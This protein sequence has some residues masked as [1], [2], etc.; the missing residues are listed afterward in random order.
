M[1]A[2]TTPTFSPR[3]AIATARFTVTELLPTP[4]LPDAT[5]IDAGQRAGLGERDLVRRGVGAADGLAQGLALRVVHHVEA[6]P[7]HAGHAGHPGDRLGD[8]GGDR[9]AHRAARHGE[10]DGDVDPAL[11]VA[12]DVLDHAE[13]GERAVD[14]R[15]LDG[16]QRGHEVVDGG[17]LVHGGVLTGGVWL[18]RPLYGGRRARLPEGRA[19]GRPYPVRYDRAGRSLTTVRDDRSSR[20]SQFLRAHAHVT[21]LL[22]AEL[23]AAHGLSLAEYDVLVQLSEAPD[24]PAADDRAGR[25]GAALPQ[26]ADPAGGPDEPGRPGP[27]EPCPDDARGTFTRDD[28]AGRHA[29]VDAART[30]PRRGRAARERIC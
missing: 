28:R 21:R 13:L 25:A 24:R 7:L 11:G 19:T 10:V 5:A 2:S 3:A 1:S 15:V 18:P 23:V 12:A 6:R 27:R 20:G 29:L 22:E 17:C 4:P 26:R 16:G 9:L 8:P 30:P 14:L